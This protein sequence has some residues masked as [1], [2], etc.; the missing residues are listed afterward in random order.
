MA[1]SQT[2]RPQPQAGPLLGALAWLAD[3][4]QLNYQIANVTAGLPLPNGDLPLSHFVEAAS[5]TGFSARHLSLPLRE[6]TAARLPCIIA[7]KGHPPTLLIEHT[8]DS[9]VLL[10]PFSLGASHWTPTELAQH[11]QGQAIV[12]KP[13]YQAQQYG[14][15]STAAINSEHWLWGPLKQAHPLYR[16]ILLASL[17]INLFALVAPLF[18]MNVYDR[19][20]PNLAYESLWVLAIGAS[21]AYLFDFVLKTIRAELIDY[22]GKKADLA[23]SRTLFARIMGMRLQHQPLSTGVLARQFGEFDA[24]RE[25]IA[26]T[27]ITTLVDLPFTVFFLALIAWLCGPLIWVPLGAILIMVL[28]T[29]SLHRRLAD[30]SQHAQQ[31]SDLRH[32]HLYESLNGLETIKSNGAE[33]AIQ[34]TWEALQSHCAQW[35]MRNRKLTNFASNSAAFLI[36]ISTIVTVILGV[37]TLANGNLSQGGIIA[38]VILSTRAISP[39]AQLISLLSRTHTVKHT[40]NALDQLMALPQELQPQHH[41]PEIGRLQGKIHATDLNYH[42]PNATQPTL[43]Q[44]NFIIEAGQRVAL[45]GRNGSGK[46][47]LA[48]LILGFL[49]TEHG[50]LHLDNWEINQLHSS[51][52]RQQIGY[53]PQDIKLF[54]GSI[55]D[56]ILLGCP[57]VP[58]EQL[59]QAV[60]RSGVALFTQFDPNGLNQSV[61]ESGRALSAGQR[62]AIALARALLNNPPLLI[63]DEPTASLDP[64]AELQFIRTINQLPKTQTILLITHKQ[65]LMAL[66]DS[67]M[68]LERGQLIAHGPRQQVLDHLHAARESA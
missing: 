61:G 27:T 34:Y 36:Q 10:D 9:V 28:I 44:L 66:V 67:I 19:I 18:I 21:V 12:I 37:Y 15:A 57:N 59:Q 16:D 56:N 33:G 53:V 11:Y 40:L 39:M 7:L 47:T 49:R 41:Y 30:A 68:V 48:K 65:A 20:V 50:G 6:L 4:Y 51:A 45:I 55:R 64:R 13:S 22:A 46:T 5:R 58:D 52:L 43:K 63:L 32:A 26:S 31:F 35:Q 29:A 17:L 8:T 2:T 3:Y 23:V 60:S 42:Y 54:Q 14:S 38:A 1:K 24:V 62:Q 25:F